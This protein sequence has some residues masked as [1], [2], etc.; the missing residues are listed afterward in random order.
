MQ[1]MC[2]GR[3]WGALFVKKNGGYFIS[4]KV[5][6]H[7]YDTH[8]VPIEITEYAVTKVWRG[9]MSSPITIR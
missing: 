2:C 1:I 7:L 9:F 6:F 3:D 5:A 8:G 4:G